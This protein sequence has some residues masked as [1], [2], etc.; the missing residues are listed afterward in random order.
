MLMHRFHEQP[1]YN[2]N[3]LVDGLIA[4]LRLKND[5][6][7]ARMLQVP[8]PIISKVRHHRT[9]VTAS[10]MLRIHEV[11]KVPVASLRRMLGVPASF[12]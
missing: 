7:L 5:A 3:G 10:L 4:D 6:A 2:P 9:P 8:A 12:N 1:G 11:T